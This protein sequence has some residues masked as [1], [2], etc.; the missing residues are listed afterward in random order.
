MKEKRKQKSRELLNLIG[1]IMGA[2]LTLPK[3]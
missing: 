3:Q 1:D 2:L